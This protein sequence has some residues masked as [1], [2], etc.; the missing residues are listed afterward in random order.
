MDR[1]VDQPMSAGALATPI[2]KASAPIPVD[3]SQNRTYPP[4]D[5]ICITERDRMRLQTQL[6][7]TKFGPVLPVW[8]ADELEGADRNICLG[9][10]ARWRRYPERELYPV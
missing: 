2:N 8:L 5:R 10:Q 7:S 9:N 6:H 4:V 1:P 3:L